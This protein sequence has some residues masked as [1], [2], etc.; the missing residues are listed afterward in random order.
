[1]NA[2]ASFSA[3]PAALIEPISGPS[4]A[5][6]AGSREVDVRRG[7]VDCGALATR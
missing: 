2:A 5:R 3:A 7:L 4:L 6:V 1:M